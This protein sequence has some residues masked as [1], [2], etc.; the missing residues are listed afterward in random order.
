MRLAD[1]VVDA[2]E[3]VLGHAQRGE[4]EVFRGFVEQAQHD[5][6]A[7]VGGQGGNAHIDGLAGN[8]HADAAILR[9]AFFG[10]VEAGHDLDA[11]HHRRMQRAVGR[12]H[13]AQHAVE[14]VADDG[15]AFVRLDVDVRGF[16]AHGLGEQGVDHADDRRVMLAVEQVFDGRQFLHQAGNV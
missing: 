12:D 8:A 11:R 10:N 4:V 5:A 3:G 16:F 7:V 2:G 6:F 9:Q 13:I 1:Q 15:L 14:A